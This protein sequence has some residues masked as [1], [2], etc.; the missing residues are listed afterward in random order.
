MF[1]FPPTELPITASP[2]VSSLYKSRNEEMAVAGPGPQWLGDKLRDYPSGSCYIEM[3]RLPYLSVRR[4]PQAVVE[5]ITVSYAPA[6][7]FQLTA[8][9]PVVAGVATTLFVGSRP[10]AGTEYD[11][12]SEL[13]DELALAHTQ[14]SIAGMR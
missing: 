12:L 6:E 10:L 3:D 4:A 2:A 5:P 9:S 11:V 14:S 13:A 1:I 7:I 8:D